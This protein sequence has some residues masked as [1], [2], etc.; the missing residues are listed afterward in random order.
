MLFWVENP[1]DLYPPSGV[2]GKIKKGR[3]L[4]SHRSTTYP[5]C[6]PTLGRFGRSWSCKTC[7]AQ[8]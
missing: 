1:E 5:C 8:R 7:R 6:L 4:T 3:L 2:R